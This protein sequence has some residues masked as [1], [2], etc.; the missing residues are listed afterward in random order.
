V[1]SLL[2]QLPQLAALRTFAVDCEV[3]NPRRLADSTPTAADLQALLSAMP[4]LRLR[5]QVAA[6]PSQWAHEHCGF[7]G[8]IPRWCQGQLDELRQLAAEQP[9]VTLFDDDEM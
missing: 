2:L 8:R 5:L 3:R 4:L 1:Q 7:D 9:R 6:T